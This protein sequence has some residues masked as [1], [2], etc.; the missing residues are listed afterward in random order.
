MTMTET[1]ALPWMAAATALLD[2]VAATQGDANFSLYSA[3]SF[4]RAAAASFAFA[5]SS[6]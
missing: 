3:T 6:R 5:S 2:R 1:R 4:F